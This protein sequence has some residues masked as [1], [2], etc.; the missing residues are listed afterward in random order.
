MAPNP[1]LL[2]AFKKLK[3]AVNQLPTSTPL[4]PSGGIVGRNFDAKRFNDAEGTIWEKID[5]AYTRCFAKIPNSNPDPKN[6]VLAGPSG[7]E[8]VLNLFET[9][10]EHPDLKHQDVFLLGL[11]INQLTD[12]VYT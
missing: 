12:L 6:N 9:V 1:E 11:K 2:E 3:G 4:G 8:L 5:C 10:I 7:M